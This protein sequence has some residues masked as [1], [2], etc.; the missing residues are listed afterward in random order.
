MKRG[1]QVIYAGPLGPRSCKL[2]DYFEVSKLQVQ[3]LICCFFFFFF[4]KKKRSLI[5]G[6]LVGSGRGAKD[7]AGL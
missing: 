4:F 6:I 2:V 3:S 5:Y 1:G 7:Q